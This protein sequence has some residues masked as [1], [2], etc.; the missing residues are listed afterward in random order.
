ML[1]NSCS[2]EKSDILY[3]NGKLYRIGDYR[4]SAWAMSLLAKIAIC[5]G[6][7]RVRSSIVLDAFQFRL[8]HLSRN[9][10]YKRCGRVWTG[11]HALAFYWRMVHRPL[12]KVWRSILPSR[13]ICYIVRVSA[14]WAVGSCQWFQ[15]LRALAICPVV[16][17]SMYIYL[18]DNLDSIRTRS[19]R[20]GSDDFDR[21]DWLIACRCCIRRSLHQPGQR[22]LY[23]PEHQI[24]ILTCTSD[25]MLI[26]QNDFDVYLSRTNRSKRWK[27]HGC[28][29]IKVRQRRH[30]PTKY[31][32]THWLFPFYILWT[33]FVASK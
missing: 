10:H 19:V 1:K 28:S 33:V 6:G 18:T 14:R 25:K 17:A 3:V 16:L 15:P 27:H 32:P 12:L 31:F 8:M 5:D 24:L 7:C 22:R 9:S 2:D 29:P 13:I 20:S 26:I 4:A 30:D 21:S 11:T 23:S